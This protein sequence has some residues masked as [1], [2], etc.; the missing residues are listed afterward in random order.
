MLRAKAKKFKDKKD[1]LQKRIRNKLL[2]STD[3]TMKYGSIPLVDVTIN[4]LNGSQIV[5]KP[6]ESLLGIH[7]KADLPKFK[8]NNLK[9]ESKN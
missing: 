3:F 7:A 8:S 4:T 6:L 2:S 1:G 9:R 5:R